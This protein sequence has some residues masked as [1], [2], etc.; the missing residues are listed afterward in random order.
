MLQLLLE[1]LLWVAN[2]ASILVRNLGSGDPIWGQGQANFIADIN[3]V[4][5]IIAT[6]LRLFL[7]EWFA[8][9]LDGTPYWQSILGKAVNVQVINSLLIARILATPYVSSVSNIDS[10]YNPSTFLY[11]FTVTVL[12]QF[13]ALSVTNIPNPPSQV[14]PQ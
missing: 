2:M 10:T 1:R 5:Q 3:A 9:T 11:T 14:L 8:N 6:R 7:G 4:A 13:G 12:T